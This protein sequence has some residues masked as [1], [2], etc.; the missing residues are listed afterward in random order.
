MNVL[1]I[2]SLVLNVIS[3]VCIGILFRRTY[4]L[5]E[6]AEE[7]EKAIPNSAFSERM[8]EEQASALNEKLEEI[9]KS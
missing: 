7:L 4:L 2:I 9:D 6:C 8:S 1:T 5:L 3:L